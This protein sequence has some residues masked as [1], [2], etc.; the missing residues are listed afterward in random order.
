MQPPRVTQRAGRRAKRGQASTGRLQGQRNKLEWGH[1]GKDRKGGSGRE[2]IGKHTEEPG[3]GCQGATTCT[4]GSRW[5][6]DPW[7]GNLRC[8]LLTPSLQP[9]PYFVTSKNS[10]TCPRGPIPQQP[11]LGPRHTPFSSLSPLRPAQGLVE[12]ERG[13]GRPWNFPSSDFLILGGLLCLCSWL[14]G[15]AQDRPGLHSLQGTNHEAGEAALLPFFLSNTRPGSKGSR[16]SPLRSL[17]P[18]LCLP[19]ALPSWDR[20]L[21][22]GVGSGFPE[23]R[24]AGE[25]GRRAW[26]GCS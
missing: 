24:R 2:G 19:P 6:R 18:V 23:G 4:G 17:H 22:P 20:N 8:P 12:E 15:R 5:G 14:W 21:G 16:S 26:Q 1:M 7:A 9:Q 10:E 25:E 11:G 13:A 3:P